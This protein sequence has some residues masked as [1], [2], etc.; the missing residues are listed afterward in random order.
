MIRYAPVLH[1]RSGP[2]ST[3][4]TAASSTWRRSARKR[5]RGRASSEIGCRIDRSPSR[6]TRT[7]PVL[8]TVD[9]G[10]TAPRPAAAR[11][12]LRCRLDFASFEGQEQ[13]PVLIPRDVSDRPD[14]MPVLDHLDHRQRRQ[15]GRQS[16]DDRNEAWVFRRPGEPCGQDSAST[17]RLSMNA[18]CPKPAPYCHSIQLAISHALRESTMA[19]AGSTCRAQPRD[20][21]TGNGAQQNGRPEEESSLGAE[22]R[23]EHVRRQ[24]CEAHI[25]WCIGI[26]QPLIRDPLVKCE[27]R[28]DDQRGHGRHRQHSAAPLPELVDSADEL[29]P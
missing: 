4:A 14:A 25:V 27:L 3:S 22:E 19:A 1:S 16:G 13:R 24:E 18:R 11:R 28:R 8:P 15:H 17:P 6:S 10:D 23:A 12:P 5:S 7:S 29:R 21:H 20:E 9:R 2:G 26:H